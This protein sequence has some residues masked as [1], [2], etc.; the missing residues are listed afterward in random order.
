MN[1]EEKGLEEKRKHLWL[2]GA[3]IRGTRMIPLRLVSDQVV[4]EKAWEQEKEGRSCLFCKASDEDESLCLQAMYIVH[5]ESIFLT[6]ILCDWM[7]Q[8][9]Y[10]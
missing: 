3:W 1:V 6:N 10:T 7:R 2:G 4:S 5:N 9:M 8:E